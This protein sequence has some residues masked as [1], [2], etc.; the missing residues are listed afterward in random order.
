MKPLK[1][2]KRHIMKEFCEVGHNN[3]VKATELLVSF[4]PLFSV[5]APSYLSDEELT[6][7]LYFCQDS[8]NRCFYYRD[9]PLSYDSSVSD[10]MAVLHNFNNFVQLLWK[11]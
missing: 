3:K 11:P 1:N 2:S 5:S 7:W 10:G 4:V 8:H 6:V 9:D